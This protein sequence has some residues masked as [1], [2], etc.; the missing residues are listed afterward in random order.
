MAK[1]HELLAV[2]IPLSNQATTV[3]QELISSFDKKRM[4]WGPGPA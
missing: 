3:R 4:H 1:L 2:E